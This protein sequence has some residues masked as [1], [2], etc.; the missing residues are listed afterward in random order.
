MSYGKDKDESTDKIRD[1]VLVVA[2]MLARGIV[3]E[4][5]ESLVRLVRRMHS[6]STMATRVEATRERR[7]W[8][9]RHAQSKTVSETVSKEQSIDA[10]DVQSK[11]D[12]D[13]CEKEQ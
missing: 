8:R 9:M 11:G 6:A 2:K 5:I 1:D 12:S 10:V 7:R 4:P 13:G 3:S